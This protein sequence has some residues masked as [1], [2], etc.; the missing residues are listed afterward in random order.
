M[1]EVDDGAMSSLLRARRA[2]T[3]HWAGHPNLRRTLRGEGGDDKTADNAPRFVVCIYHR[4]AKLRVTGNV[5]CCKLAYRGADWPK[6]RDQENLMKLKSDPD[7][8]PSSHVSSRFTRR[9]CSSGC[10]G[11]PK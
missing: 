8:W 5:I 9:A 6:S 1:A 4:P 2:C 10:M 11:K 7:A 3:R